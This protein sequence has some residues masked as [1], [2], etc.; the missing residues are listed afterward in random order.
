MDVGHNT[1]SAHTLKR[2]GGGSRR[3]PWWVDIRP[4]RRTSGAALCG[5]NWRKN[6]WLV[7]TLILITTRAP[8]T[9]VVG[10]HVLLC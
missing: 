5:G 2:P 4:S 8:S 9:V 1:V 6:D 7:L 3:P 10:V